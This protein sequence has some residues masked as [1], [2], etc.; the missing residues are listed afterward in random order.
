ME[1]KWTQAQIKLETERILN[2]HTTRDYPVQIVSIAESMGLSVYST[3]F[4]RPDIS[5]MIKPKE[6]EIYVCKSDGKQRRRF[7]IA[8][9]LGHYVLHYESGEFGDKEK[10]KHISFRDNVSSQAFDKKEIEANFFAA[11]LLMPELEVRRLYEH[12]YTLEEMAYYFNVSKAAMG[13]RLKGLELDDE[14]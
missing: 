12:A 9:E 13:Y 2:E 6:K 10:E 14:L 3:T 7:S 8:H 5:G 1:R 11:S 4:S